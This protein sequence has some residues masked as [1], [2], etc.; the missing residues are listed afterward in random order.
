[1]DN[2]EEVCHGM[3]YQAILTQSFTYDSLIAMLGIK[4]QCWA[5]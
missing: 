4:V 5:K 3:P 1:M 2:V